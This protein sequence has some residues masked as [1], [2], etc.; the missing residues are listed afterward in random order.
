MG[1]KWSHP[2][3]LVSRKKEPTM[4]EF[5]NTLP[6]YM[7]PYVWLMAI[8]LVLS[9]TSMIWYGFYAWHERHDEKTSMQKPH[10]RHRLDRRA[11]RT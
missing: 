5:L 7:M 10:H 11:R 3:H 2:I 6:D 1:V 4:L 8:A 9:L